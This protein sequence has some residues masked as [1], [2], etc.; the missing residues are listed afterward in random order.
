MQE[1][2]LIRQKAHTG[3][4]VLEDF[5]YMVMEAGS[6]TMPNGSVL[7]VGTTEVDTRTRSAS[8]DRLQLNSNFDK[9]HS[10]FFNSDL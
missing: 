8:W 2:T 10:H 5:S 6:W 3:G 9:P 1:P 7:E 4:H